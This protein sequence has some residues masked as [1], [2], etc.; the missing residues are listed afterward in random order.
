MAEIQSL[1]DEIYAAMKKWL[2]GLPEGHKRRISQHFGALPALDPSLAATPNGPAWAWWC[3][4]V[5]PIDTRIQ[6]VLL[7]MA[8]FRE[9][10]EALRKVLLYLGSRQS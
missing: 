10:L 8:S 5:L 3:A 2:G 1:Q 6:L 9:R 7:A 4:A